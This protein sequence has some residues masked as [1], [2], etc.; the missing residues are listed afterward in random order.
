M[1]SLWAGCLAESSG[2]SGIPATS[3]DSPVSTATRDGWLDDDGFPMSPPRYLRLQACLRPGLCTRR[4]GGVACSYRSPLLP[5]E[6]ALDDVV[7]ESNIPDAM[8]TE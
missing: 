2:S 4:V 7:L 5:S 8:E 6:F 1:S 3:D